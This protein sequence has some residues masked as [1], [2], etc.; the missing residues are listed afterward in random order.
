MIKNRQRS[1]PAWKAKKPSYLAVVYTDVIQGIILFVGFV[2]LTVLTWVKVGGIHAFSETLPKGM[3]SFIPPSS[4][5]GGS[6]VVSI[7]EPAS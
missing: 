3:T 5:Q 2:T 1:L 4:T 7:V 6:K